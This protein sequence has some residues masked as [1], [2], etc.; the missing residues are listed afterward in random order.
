MIH[1]KEDEYQG[2]AVVD[3]WKLSNGLPSVEVHLFN[4]NQDL[5][6]QVLTVTLL[7]KI[8]DLMQF[9]D[10][11]SLIIQIKKD[12]AIAEAAFETRI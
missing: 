10:T 5:Y 4:F 12:I 7:A 11:E 6:G 2:L 1:I 3:M 9:T 8:R